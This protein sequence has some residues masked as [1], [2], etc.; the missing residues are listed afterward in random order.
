MDF[1][2]SAQLTRTFASH[3]GKSVCLAPGKTD[4]TNQSGHWSVFNQSFTQSSPLSTTP[5][6][7][8]NHLFCCLTMYHKCQCDVTWML[9]ITITLIT[10]VVGAT[11]IRVKKPNAKHDSETS[12][13]FVVVDKW[14]SNTQDEERIIIGRDWVSC[15]DY[16]WV[17]LLKRRW[18]ETRATNH[19]NADNIKTTPSTG[20]RRQHKLHHHHRHYYSHSARCHTAKTIA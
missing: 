15:F 13:D 12:I 1:W 3:S 11:T 4:K 20:Y 19:H 10:K 5:P 9:K 2:D 16:E 7:I 17:D 6:L 8:P 14:N 18:N